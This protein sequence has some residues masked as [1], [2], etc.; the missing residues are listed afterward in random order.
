MR[1]KRA[2]DPLQLEVQANSEPSDIGICWEL[3]LGP[4]EEQQALFF[5][6]FYYIFSSITFPTLSQKSPSSKH[7]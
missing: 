7:S 5:F 6:F 3:N 1:P 2:S 4:L